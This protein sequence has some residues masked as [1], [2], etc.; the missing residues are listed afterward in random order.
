LDGLRTAAAGG[1]G[2]EHLRYGALKA[3]EKG[4]RRS[5]GIKDDK[6]E[7][8]KNIKPRGCSGE[9]RGIRSPRAIMKVF[10]TKNEIS[11]RDGPKTLRVGRD[12]GSHNTCGLR[13]DDKVM[14]KL[15]SKS[16][17]E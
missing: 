1:R 10:R 6:R 9:F 4:E 2:S 5:V 7:D 11:L 12:S 17:E 3:K 16:Q 14:R 13:A 8:L 15:R